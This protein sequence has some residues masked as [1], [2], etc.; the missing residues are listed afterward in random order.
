MCVLPDVVPPKATC[1]PLYKSG[2]GTILL[3]EIF[4]PKDE[5][6]AAKLQ[7]KNLAHQVQVVPQSQHI[8][9][10]LYKDS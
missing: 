6:P 3:A 10:D 4:S 9:L 2:N 7:Q 1:R 5:L 8:D